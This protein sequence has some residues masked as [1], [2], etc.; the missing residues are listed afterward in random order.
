MH[1][2]NNIV[3]SIVETDLVRAMIVL[4]RAEELLTD[5]A[6]KM[7]ALF[8]VVAPLFIQHHKLS[9]R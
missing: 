2:Q 1:A 5:C 6:Q 3:I 9:K 4:F 7:V 8:I